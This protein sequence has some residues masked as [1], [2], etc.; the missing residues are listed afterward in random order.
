MVDT[1]SNG[2]TTGSGRGRPVDATAA[3]PSPANSRSKSLIHQKHVVMMASGVPTVVPVLGAFVIALA[4]GISVTRGCGPPVPSRPQNASPGTSP[5]QPS[6]QELLEF[7][8]RQDMML[9]EYA[10]RLTRLE[11]EHIRLSA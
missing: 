3:T 4:A 10:K 5:G 7:I 11:S 2:N 6:R 9:S 1:R 8:R